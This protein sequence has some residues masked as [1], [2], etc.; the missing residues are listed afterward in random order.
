[1][2]FLALSILGLILVFEALAGAQSILFLLFLGFLLATVLRHPLD[3]LG[4]VLSRPVAAFLIFVA[5]VGWTALLVTFSAPIIAEQVRA[6]VDKAPRGLILVE[7]WW[8]RVVGE[9][10]GEPMAADYVTKLVRERVE[11]ELGVFLGRAVPFAFSTLTA[12]SSALVLLILAIFL[13]YDPE[14][15]VEGVVRLVPREHEVTVVSLCQRIGSTLRQWMLGTLLLMLVVGTLTGLGLYLVGIDSWFVLA[16]LMFL[17][18]FVA[19]V[20]PIVAAIP[21]LAVALTVSPMT[22]V[23]ALA[24]YVGV[25]QLENNL[26]SPL[27]M[28]RVVRLEPALLIAWQ[29]LVGST[30][31][32]AA[33][34]IATPLLA[35]VKVCVDALYVERVLGKVGTPGN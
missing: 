4:R 28:K 10:P 21:G 15:Y 7:A 27:V 6:L 9:L 17:G 32:L 2:L 24:V 33:L 5:A 31:G 3:F 12:V 18:E 30:L 35:C 8:R 1:M 26:L 14:A 11:S 34:V 29:L 23:Y 20:G 25:Q 22:A 19:Y 16:V 13:A